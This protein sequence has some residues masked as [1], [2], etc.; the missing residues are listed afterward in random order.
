MKRGS[1][2]QYVGMGMRMVPNITK[3]QVIEHLDL[4]DNNIVDFLSLG[5]LTNLQ[6]LI[7]DHNSLTEQS[8]IPYLPELR[9]FSCN[10]CC[11]SNIQLFIRKIQRCFPKLEELSLLMSPCCQAFSSNQ[12]ERL[13]Y[14]LYIVSQL[15]NL[16]MLDMTEI[17]D[18]ERLLAQRK[19]SLMTQ[20]K[21]HQYTFIQ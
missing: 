14:R 6:V 13:D 5:A 10:H 8:S 11:I 3:T 4:T 19:H 7:F 1:R 20:P 16:K 9:V 12:Q 18:E 2:A 21:T 17:T 15:H